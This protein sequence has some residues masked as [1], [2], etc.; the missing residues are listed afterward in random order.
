MGL[1]LS[2]AQFRKDFPVSD[3]TINRYLKSGIIKS[4]KIAGRVLIPASEL[5]RLA[6]I[7]EGGVAKGQA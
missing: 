4:V 7:A 1:F 3:A 5:D 6:A 2:K